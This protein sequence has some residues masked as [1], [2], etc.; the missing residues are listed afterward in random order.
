VVEEGDND[1]R[2]VANGGGGWG[3]SDD[4]EEL[5]EGDHMSRSISGEQFVEQV[6]CV[7]RGEVSRAVTLSVEQL[8]LL[9]RGVVHPSNMDAVGGG[10]CIRIDESAASRSWRA[11]SVLRLPER[12]RRPMIRF[13]FFSQ[14]LCTR[15][16]MS[17]SA[18]L[19]SQTYNGS[20]LFVGR[21]E[22]RGVE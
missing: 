3:A 16:D 7:F 4:G 12:R 22:A 10:G 17:D 20:G 14:G 8:Q 18:C 15:L 13:T 1:D 21:D 5:V 2:A 19:A 11:S 9:A 6:Q